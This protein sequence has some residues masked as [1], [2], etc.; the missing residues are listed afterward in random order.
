MDPRHVMVSVIG[1]I[2]FYFFASPVIS[3]LWGEDTLSPE[4]IRDRK[5]EVTDFVIHAILPEKG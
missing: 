4:N 2:L 5:R 3:T 1:M